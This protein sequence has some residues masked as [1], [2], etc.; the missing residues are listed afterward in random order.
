M[1]FQYGGFHMTPANEIKITNNPFLISK[2]YIWFV[3]W[4]GRS[5]KRDSNPWP[6]NWDAEAYT[7][8]LEMQ[9]KQFCSN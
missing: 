5:G 6:W 1:K 3:Q 7:W 9:L 2:A 4:G 8:L